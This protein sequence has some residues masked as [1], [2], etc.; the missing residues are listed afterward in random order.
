L[1]F[2]KP[3]NYKNISATQLTD[4]LD[5][6][7]LTDLGLCCQP[8]IEAIIFYNEQ[9]WLQPTNSH[10]AYYILPREHLHLIVR[11]RNWLNTTQVSHREWISSFWLNDFGYI[12]VAS[13]TNFD[14]YL[15]HHGSNKYYGTSGSLAKVSTIIGGL[16]FEYKNGHFFPTTS[17][18]N[19][20][21][22]KYTVNHSNDI[23]SCFPLSF[24]RIPKRSHEATPNC[25]KLLN[26]SLT[27]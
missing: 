20:H 15:V 25:S 5:L 18:T 26:I 10:S 23:A 12:R 27:D 2:E 7:R 22:L 9:W 11:D 6:W 17:L 24:S 13:I 3:A 19:A 4:N 14:Q 8:L 16:G 21:L 1:R